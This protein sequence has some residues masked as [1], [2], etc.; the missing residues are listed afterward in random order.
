MNANTAWAQAFVAELANC[1]LQAVCLAPGSRSTPL[2]LAFSRHPE[3]AVYL[4]LDERSAGFFALGMAQAS[5]RP[6]AIVCTSGTAAAEFHPAIIEALQAQVPL[7]VLTAD[8]PHELRYS[9]ANQTVDQIKLYGDHVLWTVDSA[10]PEGDP[11]AVAMRNLRAL[12][13]RAYARADGQRRGPVHINFPFRKPLE[14]ASIQDLPQPVRSSPAVHFQRGEIQPTQDQIQHLAQLANR[15]ERG[16]ILCGPRCPGGRFPHAVAQLARKTGYPLLVD[17]LS[18]VRF[19]PHTDQAP[20]VGGYET[21]LHD[22]NV[23]WNPPEVVVRFGAVPTSKQLNSYLERSAPQHLV[24]IEESGV[25]ADESHLTSTFYQV[26]ATALCLEAAKTLP[27]QPLRPWALEILSAENIYWS[28]W[29]HLRQ[30][31]FF[32]GAVVAATVAATP[33]L[34]NLVI[35]NSLP[36]RHLDQFAAPSS[37]PL[38]VFGNRGASGIDGVT[39]SALGVAAAS[40]RRTVLITGDVSFYHDLNGLLAIGQQSLKRV[41]IV[42][43]NNGGG[44][45]FRRLP[46]AQFEPPF[47]S[48]FLTPHGLNFAHAAHLYGLGH[49]LAT[50]YASFQAALG[51]ALGSDETHIVEVQTDSAEDLQLRNRVM[52]LYQEAIKASW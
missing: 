47:T 16:L 28:K 1:G 52:Q 12:A 7:L 3:I 6:V 18:G 15:Y 26:D 50:D 39:S 34:S 42:V 51:E 45:I 37:K 32:D 23:P 20:L 31:L 24:Q 44:G 8:R 48:L 35:G 2:A 29:E 27:G 41:T 21:L 33:P 38:H 5:Q 25:W 14:P 13:C 17:P 30:N 43:L 36:V 46:V 40:G 10:L 22:V 19:G 11:P 4:H 9:G 49:Q